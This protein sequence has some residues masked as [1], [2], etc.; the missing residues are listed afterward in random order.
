[1]LRSELEKR[2]AERKRKRRSLRRENRD[3]LLLKAG[4]LNCSEGTGLV[5]DKTTTTASIETRD[6][7]P[8]QSKRK[9]EFRTWIST[10]ARRHDVADA[11]AICKAWLL[12]EV[13]ASE[14]RYEVLD[15]T[16]TPRRGPS[17]K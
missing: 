6:A 17:S 8:P 4:A 13:T 3:L 15:T 10:A 12:D 7:V 16:T 1:M 9:S 2:N 5:V 11:T 14:V